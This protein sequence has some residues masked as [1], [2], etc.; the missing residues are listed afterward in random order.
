MNDK[1]GE[2]IRE[3][4]AVKGQILQDP[5]LIGSGKGNTYISVATGE[6]RQMRNIWPPN[7]RAGFLSTGTRCHRKLCTAIPAI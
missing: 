4:I 3:S 7:F 6:V 1:I 5:A 2:I